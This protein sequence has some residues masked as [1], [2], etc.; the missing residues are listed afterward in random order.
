MPKLSK[1]TQL[2]IL[3]VLNDGFLVSLPL[4]LP[5]LQKDLALSLTW[6]GFLGTV[7]KSFEIFLALPASYFA[8]KIGSL[9]LLVLAIF[10]YGIGYLFAGFSTNLLFITIAFLLA[11]LGFGA[12]HP[13]AFSLVDNWSKPESRGRNMGNFAAIGDIGRL[14]IASIVTL[15]AGYI[16]W[17]LTSVLY[18]LLA[19][20]MFVV[21]IILVG[22]KKDQEE[23]EQDVVSKNR[24]GYSFLRGKYLLVTLTGLLDSLSSSALFVFIPFLLL[25]RGASVDYLGSLTAAF[26]VGN[27][28]GKAG[29]GR[30]VDRFGNKRVF[31]LAEL[32]MAACLLMITQIPSVIAI[33]IV[34]V[35]LGALTKGTVPVI[36]TMVSESLKIGDSKQ[37]AY[38]F[39]NF[40][41]GMASTSA[42][43]LLGMASDA[44][45]IKSAFYVSAIMAIVATL[46]VM[47]A[48]KHKL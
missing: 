45:G 23:Y 29:M 46:P 10:I 12:F 2:N 21:F 18:G 30:M 38:G 40:I 5:F 48:Q 39:N 24:K 25:Y 43:L 33:V 42:P 1:L 7:L 34:S 28:L 26:F 9:R 15:I 22:V 11:G 44:F 37:R 13:V 6:V 41:V 4:L 3:H 31:I 17:R 8:E 32:V 20:G 19:I 36:M 35:I 16:G 27:M 14:G 47:V